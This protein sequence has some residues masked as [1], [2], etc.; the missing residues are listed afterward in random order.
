MKTLIIFLFALV[1]S[2]SFANT[3]III[4]QNGEKIEANYVA[5]KDKVVYYTVPGSSVEQEISVYAVEKIVD[6]TSNQTLISNSKIDVSG[7]LGFKNVVVLNAN[8]AKGLKVAEEF[9]AN[10][11][12]VKGQ[13]QS[14]WVEWTENRIKREAAAK[15]YS[16]ILITEQTDSKIKAVAYTY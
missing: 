5:T 1:S 9:T 8:Q 6:K 11:Q 3:H 7:K 12:K 10:I 4:K 16:Y 14:T 2:L 15:G 13:S